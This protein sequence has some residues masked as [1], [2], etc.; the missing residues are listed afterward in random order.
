VTLVKDIQ[1]PFQEMLGKKAFAAARW[2]Q[3]SDDKPAR[4]KPE[5]L[6]PEAISSSSLF[7]SGIPNERTLL[8]GVEVKAT[9]QTLMK[10]ILTLVLL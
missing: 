5:L 8:V 6:Y 2:L 1:L 4:A 10:G 9:T 7:L 3:K